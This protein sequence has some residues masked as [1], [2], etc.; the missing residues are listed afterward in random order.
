MI[1]RNSGSRLI[2]I[3]GSP[4]SGTTLVQNMLDSHPEVLGGPEF[5]HLDQFILLRKKLFGSIDRGWIDI[6]CSKEDVDRYL[7]E[8]IEKLFLHLADSHNCKYYSEKTPMNILVFP[9]LVELVPKAHF[10][11]VIRDPRAI[12]ASMQ[13]VKNRAV[14]KGFS[15][16][17][18]T[19]NLAA[20]IEYVKN[21]FEAGFTAEKNNPGKVLTILYENLISNP[22]KETKKICG[23]LGIE[24]NEQ[25]LYPGDKE[26]LGESAIT[27][28]SDELWYDKDQYY[29]N[30]ESKHIEK[31]RRNLTLA[32]KIKTM[33]AFKDDPVLKQH[34]Y[35]FSL[36]NFTQDNAILARMIYACLVAGK[37][38]Y[39]YLSKIVRRIPGIRLFKRGLLAIVRFI[40]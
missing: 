12:V 26:H 7:N 19:A 4:R 31:W 17:S 30:V 9:E 35:D 23:F 8:F 25:M 6:I 13:K 10:I 36:D 38:S 40:G 29:R 39:K 32:Q 21:C 3:G 33:M 37:T 5:I 20:S 27:V 22:E 15:P 34:G 28:N 1:E 11:H 24:W 14:A 16:P 2:F 18:F